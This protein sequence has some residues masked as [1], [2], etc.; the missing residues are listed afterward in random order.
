M[1]GE[2]HPDGDRSIPG[3][4]TPVQRKIL[5]IPTGNPSTATAPAPIS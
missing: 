4:V 1:Q 5:M 3:N 2:Y